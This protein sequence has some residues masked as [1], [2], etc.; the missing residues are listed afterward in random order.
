MVLSDGQLNREEGCATV[1]DRQGNLLFY[2]DG[3]D[4]WNRQH[5]L[6]LNGFMISDYISNSQVLI[7]PLPGSDSIFYVFT[8]MDGD[9]LSPQLGFRYAIV[10][11]NGDNGLGEVVSKGNSLFPNSSE[12]VCMTR[13]E[14]GVDLWILA[15]ERPDSIFRAYRLTCDGLDTNYVESSVG[16]EMPLGNG[17]MKFSH[18]G[19]KVAMAI[20]GPGIVQLFDFDRSTGIVSN[21]FTLDSLERAYG[22]EFSPNDSVLYVTAALP[23]YL[24]HQF[25]LSSDVESIIN[26]SR[27]IIPT[28]G[29]TL[30]KT[31]QM[32]IDGK[33]YICNLLF[34]YLSIIQYPDLLFPACGYIDMG[35]FYTSSGPVGGLGG[36]LPHIYP[37][38]PNSIYSLSSHSPLCP[39]DSILLMVSHSHTPDSLQWI[40]TDSVS[41]GVQTFSEDTIEVRFP[42]P[43]DYMGQ[44]IVYWGCE[45]DTQSFPISVIPPPVVSLPD[46]LLL[47][48]NE[49][50]PLFPDPIID[51]YSYQ[52][53]TIDTF[54][55][56]LVEEPGIYW[57]EASNQ[58][59]TDIDSTLVEQDE[60]EGVFIPNVFTPNSDGINDLFRVEVRNPEQYHIHIFDRW[61]R[62]VFDSPNPE[63][64]WDGQNHKAG[65]FYYYLQTLDCKGEKEEYKGWVTLLR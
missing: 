2:T 57:L 31:I 4:V 53:S 54:P 35:F 19:K 30:S 61:G 7:A 52:W 11:M 18:D 14:N 26:S 17:Y 56:I 1:S 28:F 20:I 63:F 6:M 21:P 8:T 45:P 48:G 60:D 29:G 64:P 62:K 13:A 46:S 3:V 58:C 39:G 5:Q 59:G 10:D 34:D 43:G 16:S 37:P 22:V 55:E 65:L 51:T 42:D 47:C 33:L 44:L 23:D 50:K 41:G 38:K 24:L 40:F 32:G 49:A 36:G 25:D 12:K 15:H 27:T 9:P